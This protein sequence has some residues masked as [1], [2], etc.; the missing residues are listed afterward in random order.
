MTVRRFANVLTS[1]D[2]IQYVCFTL[3]LLIL[4]IAQLFNTIAVFLFMRK[5]RAFMNVGL[6]VCV[7]H[8]LRVI[9]V[10]NLHSRA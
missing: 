7:R 5:G 1:F 10:L 4:L 8:V 2:T 6:W 3:N 9:T